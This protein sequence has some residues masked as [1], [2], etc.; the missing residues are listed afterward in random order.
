MRS[1]F[2]LNIIG[3]LLT[4]ASFC[5]ANDPVQ[6]VPAQ[7]DDNVI[8]A[9]WNVKWFGSSDNH[10]F[11]GLAKVISHF[12]ICGIMEVKKESEFVSLVTALE[13][14]TKKDWG[15][16]FGPR[17]ARPNS[18]YYESFGFVWRRDRVS[19]GDGVVSNVW[20]KSEKYRN[21]PFI[22]SFKRGDFDFVVALIHTRWTDDVAGTREAEILGITEQ[23]KHMRSY[24]TE[25][26]FILSGDFNESGTAN[27][28]AKM[29]ND[30]NLRQIDGNPKSTFK[31]DGTGYSSAY[32]HMYIGDDSKS[33][34]GRLIGEAQTLDTSFVAY[35]DNTQANMQRARKELSDHLP[36]FAVFKV[37]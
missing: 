18:T 3:V 37:N 29:A 11:V 6:N 19:L 24:V 30:S 36:I 22:S 34:F 27:A 21:D 12:D 13:D 28:M 26:D 4:C 1:I 25:E 8:V 9:A 33:T 17:T 32:D 7:S 2:E 5:Y 10:D 35:G 23:I 15:Y 16:V 31:S 20:D 14:L